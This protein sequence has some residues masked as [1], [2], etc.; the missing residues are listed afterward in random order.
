MVRCDKL[1]KCEC[2]GGR[3]GVTLS[4]IRADSAAGFFLAMFMLFRFAS[5]FP[6]MLL[7]EDFDWTDLPVSQVSLDPIRRTILA[8]IYI[9]C[10]GSSREKRFLIE[11][12]R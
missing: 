5:F 11:I 4:G 7:Y 9:R 8:A 10:S 2:C 1:Q 6:V 3:W 12:G